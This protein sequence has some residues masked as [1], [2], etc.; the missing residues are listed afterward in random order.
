MK[1]KKTISELINIL[2]SSGIEEIEITS[3]WGAQKIRVSNKNTNVQ[4]I[5]YS[6]DVY[7]Q[8]EI[9]KENQNNGQEIKQKK[10]ENIKKEKVVNSNNYIYS[11]LV[12]TFYTSSKPDEPPFVSEGDEIEIGKTICIIE[13]IKI[14]NEIESETSGKIVKILVKDG[15]PV[16]YDQ[17]LM[18]IE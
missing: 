12:G 1:L 3:F 17:P 7:V 11:P 16:E 18:I 15:T 6:N 8:E 4:K 13:A 14:F 9:V 10:V 2:K 5:L